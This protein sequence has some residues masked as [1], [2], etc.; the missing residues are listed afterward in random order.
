M[1]KKKAILRFNPS[2]VEKPI[3]Y[4][5]IKKYELWIN[6]L[7]AKFEPSLG[8]KLVIEIRGDKKQIDEAFTYLK[9]QNIK[10]DFLEQE[11]SWN[12]L[13]CN[14]CG[15]CVSICPVG[16]LIIN[17]QTYYLEFNYQDCV[18]CGYCADACPVQAIEIIF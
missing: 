6:I 16:A 15:A 13:K 18:V 3:T 9:E 17:K 4:Y 1:I 11:I 8:G 12:K 7:Q 14:H 5:L 10:V 2:T